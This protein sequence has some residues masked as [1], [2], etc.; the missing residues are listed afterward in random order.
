MTK[1]NRELE[2]YWPHHF[3]PI[4]KGIIGVIVCSD[5]SRCIGVRPLHWP[6]SQMTHI[7]EKDIGKYIRFI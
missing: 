3:R 7:P 4:S 5:L 2:R 1:K 6:K